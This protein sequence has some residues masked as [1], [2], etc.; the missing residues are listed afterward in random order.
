MLLKT[1]LANTYFIKQSI[2]LLGDIYD[3]CDVCIKAFI[4]IESSQILRKNCQQSFCR[5]GAN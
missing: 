5:F 2:C 4:I 1:F 3:R